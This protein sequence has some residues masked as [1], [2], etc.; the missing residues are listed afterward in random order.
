MVKAKTTDFK[1]YLQF[2][3]YESGRCE[4]CSDIEGSRWLLL[5]VVQRFQI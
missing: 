3:V 5:T 4:T 1:I 2:E